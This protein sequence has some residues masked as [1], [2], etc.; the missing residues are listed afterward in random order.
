VVS[1]LGGSWSVERSQLTPNMALILATD[2]LLEQAADADFAQLASQAW[3][4]SKGQAR[5]CLDLL[6]GQA[7]EQS[8][9]WPDDVTVMIATPNP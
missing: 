3:T 7:R 8:Q 2:G 5:E 4:E 1:A 9:D 6:V